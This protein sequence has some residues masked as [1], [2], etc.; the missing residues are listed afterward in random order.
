MDMDIRWQLM[1]RSRGKVSVT[2]PPVTPMRAS[3]KAQTP[4]TSCLRTDGIAEIAGWEPEDVSELGARQ[5][6]CTPHDVTYA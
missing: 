1:A 2:T 5:T 4:C 6:S 3:I